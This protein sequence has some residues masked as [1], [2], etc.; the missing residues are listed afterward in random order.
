M[1]RVAI[2]DMKMNYYTNDNQGKPAL[3]FIHGL[4]ENLD[5]WSYQ[6]KAFNQEYYVIAMDLRGHGLSSDGTA[7]LSMDQFAG[8]VLAL[9][10]YL[11]VGCAHFIGL[12]MGG[13]VC[14]ELTIHH[15]QRMLSLVLCNTAAFPADNGSYPLSDRLSMIEQT[16]ME[17]M[18]DY[19]T[20]AC[21]SNPFTASLY[22]QTLDMFKQNRTIPYMAA[23][24]V[25]YTVDYRSILPKIKLPTLIIAGEYDIVTPVWTAEYLHEHIPG[26][27]LVVIPQVGHLTKLE[28]PVMFNQ[29]LLHFL[30]NYTN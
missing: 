15:Q 8:D 20:Q 26:S 3:V 25:A 11:D 1:P 22:N 24:A 6:F 12:S 7:E 17:I 2:N 5:S 9:L 13:M 18:A 14:Q 27:E 30:Q 16:P 21:L 19:A 10:N 23:T 28:N 4:G 29:V